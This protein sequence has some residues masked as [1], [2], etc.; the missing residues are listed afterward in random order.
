MTG[1][2]TALERRL[3]TLPGG[4]RLETDGDFAD[5]LGRLIDSE[6]AKDAEALDAALLGEA[7]DA[8]LCFAAKDAEAIAE[9]A[10]ANA[11]AFIEERRA[12]RRVSWKKAAVFAAAAALVASLAAVALGNGFGILDMTKREWNELTPDSKFIA[13]E[14]EI[15]KAVGNRAYDD[16]S[17]LLAAEGF[18]NVTAPRGVTS[19]GARVIE[20]VDCRDILTTLRAAD[21][22]TAELEIVTPARYGE[23]KNTT[24]IAAFDVVVSNYDGVWQ[25]EWIENGAW[26]CLQTDGEAAL[27]SF[28]A[29]FAEN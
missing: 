5:A 8:L 14:L 28:I 20:F 1:E 17:L 23:L 12:K 9:R 7:L 10:A 21:G 11:R 13:G 16:L 19:S 24:R 25:G 29:A 15:A 6:A 4:A 22:K 26:Y 3:E 27:H 18:E 2:L